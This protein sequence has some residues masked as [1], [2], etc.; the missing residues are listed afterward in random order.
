MVDTLAL[1]ASSRKG[2]SVQ[3][4]PAAHVKQLLHKEVV[5]MN[6]WAKLRKRSPRSPE[7]AANFLLRKFGI[8]GPPV[9]VE[10]IATQGLDVHLLRDPSL[11]CSGAVKSE[12]DSA[13][14]V[15]NDADG[16]L[17]QRFTIAHALGHL[18]LHQI[19]VEFRDTTFSGTTLET[20]ANKF[21]AA[22]LVPLWMLEDAALAP[23]VDVPALARWFNV[24]E[25]TMSIRLQQL[26]GFPIRWR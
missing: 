18:M 12:H 21:A 17:R 8:G 4:R 20:E 7:Q 23:R 26:A 3:I 6:N 13:T 22:L 5:F 10:R 19:G 15:V 14:I 9:P 1:G 25:P 11:D 24:S 2:L 16:P